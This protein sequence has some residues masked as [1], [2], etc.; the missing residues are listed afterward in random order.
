MAEVLA[1]VQKRKGQGQR[2][3]FQGWKV[4]FLFFEI[5]FLPRE[6]RKDTALAH[7][8]EKYR[9]IFKILSPSDSTMIVKRND[10]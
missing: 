9:P 6:S 1:M 4:G 3:S 8:F 2:S 5:L 7:N 10:N